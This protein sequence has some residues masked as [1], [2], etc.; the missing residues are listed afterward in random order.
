[1]DVVKAVE[2]QGS[3]SGQTAKVIKIEACGQL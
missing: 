3:E 1:M 2:A